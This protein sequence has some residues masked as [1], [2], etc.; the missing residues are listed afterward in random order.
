MERLAS[1]IRI[2]VYAQAGTASPPAS[3]AQRAGAIGILAHRINVSVTLGSF[4]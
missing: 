1:A 4:S 2:P 3:L